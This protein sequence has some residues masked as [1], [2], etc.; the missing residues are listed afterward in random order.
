MQLKTML[1]LRERSC[2]SYSVLGKILYAYRKIEACVDNG[3]C[4]LLNILKQRHTVVNAMQ[5][6]NLYRSHKKLIRDTCIGNI[7]EHRKLIEEF[8]YTIISSTFDSCN[9]K[10]FI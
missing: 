1:Q 3:G 6:M 4:L 9:I 7:I 10:Q 5:S 2:L 8:S